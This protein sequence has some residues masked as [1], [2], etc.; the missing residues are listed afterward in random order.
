MHSNTIALEAKIYLYDL[1]NC[2]REIGFKAGEEWSLNQAS[3]KEKAECKRRYYP[4]VSTKVDPEDLTEL[5]GLV[6]NNLNPS[7]HAGRG[8]ET[9]GKPDENLIFGCL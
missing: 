1:R 3:F 6:S 9:V 2:A 5:F 8:A 7:G 4:T